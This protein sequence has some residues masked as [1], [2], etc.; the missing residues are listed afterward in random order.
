LFRALVWQVTGDLTRATRWASNGGQWLGYGLIALGVLQALG[1]LVLGGMWLVFIGWFL[2]T[3]AAYSFR[4]HLLRNA[5]EGVR[6]RDVMTSAPNTV[7]PDLTVEAL[8]DEHMLR[9]RHHG[10]PVVE[11]GELV[12]LVTL[13][14]VKSTPREAWPSTRVREIMASDGAFVVA[15]DDAMTRVLSRMEEAGSSRVVVARGGRVEGIISSSDIT[16]WFQREQELGELR[17]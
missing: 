3:A 17:T 1:G 14:Q 10:F 4:Q 12:G 13:E 6:A 15:P 7:S 5:L 2:R 8:V 11:D 16:R 9:E